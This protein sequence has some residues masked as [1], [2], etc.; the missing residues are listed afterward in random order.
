MDTMRLCRIGLLAISLL[1]V[2]CSR[3]K[4]ARGAN[5]AHLITCDAGMKDC[6]T[7]AAKICGDDGYTI[8]AGASS[9]ELLGGSSSSNRQISERGGMEIV[10][11]LVEVADENECLEL[12]PRQDEAPAAAPTPAAPAQERHCVPGSTQRCVGAGACDGGQV[13]A[14]NGSGFGACDCGVPKPAPR[15]SSIVAPAPVA[16]PT[17]E[18]APHEAPAPEPLN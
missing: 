16:P 17:T 1:S 2:A 8:L 7:Q 4:T 13:C 9:S 15:A 14:E 5:G 18:K 11:G 12:P 3:T 6:V 10:C